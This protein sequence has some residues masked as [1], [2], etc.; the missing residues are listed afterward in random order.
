MD[1]HPPGGDVLPVLRSLQFAHLRGVDER[2]VWMEQEADRIGFE[3]LLLGLL[4]DADRRR[5]PERQVSSWGG[6]SL[7]QTV[8]GALVAR[9]SFHYYS[10]FKKNVFVL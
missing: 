10:L 2:A 5:S 9:F 8:G 1:V 7:K 4:P 6:G 3:Q